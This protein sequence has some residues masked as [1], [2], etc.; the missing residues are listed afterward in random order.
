MRFIKKYFNVLLTIFMWVVVFGIPALLVKLNPP[1]AEAELV[2]FHAK[3]LR[4][5]ETSPN[6][7]VET[8]NGEHR[9]LRFPIPLYMLFGSK[10]DFLGLSAQQEFRL[11]GCDAEIYGSNIR[12]LWPAAFRVSKIDCAT[13]PI[14]YSQIVAKFTSM[15]SNSEFKPWFELLVIGGILTITFVQARK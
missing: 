1:P 6:L 14:T 4:V 3:I 5:S 10:T 9:R 15:N 11:S 12:Y 2:H 7:V 13:A 8:T